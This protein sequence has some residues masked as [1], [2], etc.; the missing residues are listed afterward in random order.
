[1]CEGTPIARHSR[2]RRSLPRTPRC[3]ISSGGAPAPWC[4]SQSRHT[5][6]NMP[7]GG[8]G[9]PPTRPMRAS[10]RRASLLSGA[11]CGSTTGVNN[12]RCGGDSGTQS[13]RAHPLL[14]RR[15]AVIAAA[16]NSRAQDPPLAC[17]RTVF[18]ISLSLRLMTPPMIS[19]GPPG[20]DLRDESRRSTRPSSL[21]N[22]MTDLARSASAPRGR[23][24]RKQSGMSD[25]GAH[26]THRCCLQS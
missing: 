12:W 5:Q 14:S 18:T 25:E 6:R 15:M 4:S 1:M 21:L 9:L 10:A 7:S 24:Q 8:S 2:A 3:A 11:S 19:L 20:H 22:E 23:T 17:P 26:D 13:P 16:V